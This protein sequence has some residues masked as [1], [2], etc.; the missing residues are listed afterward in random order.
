MNSIRGLDFQ[1]GNSRQTRKPTHAA[2]SFF[3][4]LNLN[5]LSDRK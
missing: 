4:H 5:Y 2:S 1:N 3:G